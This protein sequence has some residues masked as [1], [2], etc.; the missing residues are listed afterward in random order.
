MESKNKRANFS[1]LSHKRNLKYITHNTLSKIN[2][3]LF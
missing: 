2:V 1:I 3:K